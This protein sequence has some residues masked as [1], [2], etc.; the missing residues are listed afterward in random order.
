MSPST[1][2]AD[3]DLLIGAYMASGDTAFIERILANFSSADDDMAGDAMRLGFM[4]S[5]FGPNVTPK[6]RENVMMPAACARYQCKTD[7][8]QFFRV[9]TLAS[10]FWALQSLAQQDEGIRKTFDRFFEADARLK[11]L[12]AAEG[13]AFGNYLTAIAVFAAFKPDKASGEVDLT[14]TA[15]GKAASAYENL[16]PAHKV[17]DHIEAYVK[18]G[19]PAK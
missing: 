6:G 4:S 11:H 3:N 14:S 17:F 2:P 8:A 7:R 12:R 13:A 15:M 9:L 10:A 5:K 18:S 1:T 19:K 16:E